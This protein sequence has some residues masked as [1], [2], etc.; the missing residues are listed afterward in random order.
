M[1]CASCKC[2]VSFGA[3][4]YSAQSGLLMRRASMQQLLFFHALGY[5]PKLKS[6]TIRDKCERES[7]S[8]IRKPFPHRG[9]L[10]AALVTMYVQCASALSQNVHIY[11][12]MHSDVFVHH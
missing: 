3:W 9:F 2:I 5:L 7:D 4:G 12:A 11:R 10:G 6:A 8:C 1:L